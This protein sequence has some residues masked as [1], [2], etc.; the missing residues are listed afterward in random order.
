MD[1]KT[2]TGFILI[3]LMVLFFITCRKDKDDPAGGNKIELGVNLIDTVSY[4][5]TGIQTEV[6]S[7]G[8]NEII[9]HGHCWNTEANPTINE[10]HTVLG[11]LSSEIDFHSTIDTLL[12]NT[13]YYIRPYIQTACAVAYGEEEQIKTLKTGKPVVSTNPVLNITLT[14]ALCG[15]IVSSDSGLVV[16]AR[17]V[18]WDTI[19]VFRID[20]CL[21]FTVDSLGLGSFSSGVTSLHEGTTYYL[22]AYATNEKGTGYGEIMTFSTIPVT[23][24]VVVTAEITNITTTSAQC[25][26]NVTSDGLGTVTLRGV[27]WDT[28]STPTFENNL[29]HTEDGSGTGE[30][31]SNIINLHEGKTY[32][33]VAYASNEKGIGYGEV[34]TFTATAITT[35]QVTAANVTTIAAHTAQCGGNVTNNGN[36]FIN[37][38]GV[39]WNNTNN[40]TLTNCL[41]H[42]EDGSGMGS[43]TSII[44]GLEDDVTYYVLAYATNENF[45][46]YGDILSF[47]TFTYPSVTT[48]PVTNITSTTA[49]SGGNITDDGG[50]PV[51]GRGVC[52]STLPD[53]T[54][55]DPHTTNGSGTGGFVSNIT[56]LTPNT[57]Y[58]IRAYAYNLFGTGYGNQLI[59]TTLTIPTVITSPVSNISYTTATSGGNV[60]DD[61]GSP[62]TARGVCWSTSQN[63]TI[64]N[65]HTINGAGVGSYI[66]N[67]TGLI[68]NT[69]YYVRAYATNSAGSAYG[70]Q[71]SFTT[72]QITLPT[73]TTSSITNISYNS[74]MSGGNVTN[75]GGA[76]VTARGV[77]WSTL[78]DPTIS[79]PH[80]NNGTGTGSFV[81]NITGLTQNTTYYVRAYAIN[82]VGTG[83]GNEI[84]FTT[85]EITNPTVTTNSVTNILYTTVTTGGNVTDDGGATVT[86][87][88][89]CWSTLQ[90]P[91]ILD[92]Y[93]TDGLGTGSFVSNITGL[94]QNTTYYVRAYATNIMGTGYGN[95]LSF[96]TLN[97]PNTITYE[98]QTYN[99]VQIG[100]QCW[101]KENLNVGSMISGTNEQTNNGTKEKYCYNNSSANC[102]TYGGLYQ[103][104]EMMQY[105]T[106]QGT[107]GLCPTGWHIPN[108]LE[109]LELMN[110]LGVSIAG[111][112]MKTTGTI[113]AG[114]GLWYAPNFGA[115]NESDFT[116]LPGGVRITG[117][118]FLTL[119]FYADFWSSTEDASNEAYSGRLDKDNAV[120]YNDIATTESYGL[121]VRCLKD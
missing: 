40:P 102:T 77:C 25:G 1:M 11:E 120:F 24:P 49:T 92:N 86:A 116:G 3:G 37:V 8:G 41:G 72:L 101:F 19:A 84:S 33:V 45:T 16:T 69:T 17:G 111:G 27:C 38:R 22:A 74:A 26:G 32:Y 31:T 82:S 64:Y 9:Q 119:G 70:N 44:T 107:K 54:I 4:F 81:S 99:T 12:P 13:V 35:P 51:N 21:G 105:T 100:T 108:H 39:C 23:P 62:V 60:T 58:Y 95:E 61:G 55:S 75:D 89:V 29:G 71:V 14:S 118:G 53:P 94:T 87:R 97:C 59:F 47:T 65:S 93:T 50:F 7:L 30:F 42:T 98:G 57:I 83:Y 73:V 34:K 113:E 43:F 78:P 80:T 20:S 48:N 117:G 66:S 96:T 68:P 2:K 28:L 6:I 88:G 115:T 67:I 56:G 63:P 5:F 18:C 85:L 46:G 103:W 15:G 109:L 52:W 10:S 114:T 112:K 110:Y 76:T 121:S 36:G 104:D 90:N 91:T 79:D 106:V